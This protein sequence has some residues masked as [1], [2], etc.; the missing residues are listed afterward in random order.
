MSNVLVAACSFASARLSGPSLGAWP[1]YLFFCLA[2]LYDLRDP[3][4]VAQTTVSLLSEKAPEK[5]LQEF[6]A[7]KI[8]GV[9]AVVDALQVGSTDWL[10]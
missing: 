9:A 7:H 3:E 5:R 1:L 2:E 4:G 10:E 8:A 6:L